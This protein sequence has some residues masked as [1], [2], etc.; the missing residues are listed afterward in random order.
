MDRKI[1]DSVFAAWQDVVE[2]KKLDPV[3]DKENDKHFKDRDDKDIDNDG[4]VDSSDEYLH[5]KRAA[6]DD[7]I[8][9]GKKPAKNVKKEDAADKET[10]PD[11]EQDSQGTKK[12]SECDGSTENHDEECSHYKGKTDTKGKK[13]ANEGVYH[14]EF[15]Y[16]E[17]L[18]VIDENYEILFSHGVEFKVTAE[19]LNFLEAKQ[20]ADA[21]SKEEISS[22]ESPKGKKWLKDMKAGNTDAIKDDEEGHDDASKAGR[23]TKQAPSRGAAD[24]LSNG[25]KKPIK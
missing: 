2:K 21:T 7:A 15:G 18:N 3:N 12:C 4:D 16:G 23:V 11:I 20:Y 1:I 14:S 22:K 8:D 5:K 24:N 25:D 17:V 10:N 6:T 13:A 19:H 9:G